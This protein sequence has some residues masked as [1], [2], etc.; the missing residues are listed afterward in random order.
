LRSARTIAAL[1]T[2]AAL[3]ACGPTRSALS[4][5]RID[6]IE[7]RPIDA[8]PDAAFRAAAG[9]MFDRG[10]FITL[11]DQ[12]AGLV[13]GSSWYSGPASDGVHV[14]ASTNAPTDVT[15]WVRP[16]SAGRTILRVQFA[17][18]GIPE[19]DAAQVSRFA[20]EVGRRALMA[21]PT[22]STP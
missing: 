9:V 12:G 18:A 17:R 5:A 21:A 1:L 4:P 20:D 6:A 13:A 3:A 7:S 15:V 19:P 22:R 11:S 16:D 8:A 10:M 14:H 2:T